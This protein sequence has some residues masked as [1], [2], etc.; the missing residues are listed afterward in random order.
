MERIEHFDEY[1]KIRSI[2]KMTAGR[3]GAEVHLLSG[4]QVAKYVK[5][6]LLSDQSAWEAYKRESLFYSEFS[7]SDHPYIPRVLYNE[8]RED[9]FLLIMRVYHPI[10]QSDMAKPE[11]L[12]KVL[13]TLRLIH[14]LP[15]PKFVPQTNAVPLTFD[16]E[17]LARCHNGWLSVLSGY[18]G[19][20]SV[21]ELNE[22]ASSIN[23]INRRLYQPKQCFV[24]GDFHCENILMDDQ[25]NIIVCDWQ[26]CG[27]GDA[28][29]DISFLLSRLS[30]DMQHVDAEMALALYCDSDSETK[31][32]LNQMRLSNLNTSFLYWHEYLH[33]APVERVANVFTNMTHDLRRLREEI[34]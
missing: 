4:R 14:G 15:I 6:E 25:R 16:E 8:L 26:N 7:S 9:E 31:K 22:V 33:G 5:R 24:H 30:A 17:N 28:S 10:S 21:H 34:A 1:L 27:V 13:S 11:I 19:R 2:K 18:D 12:G 23:E 20:F 29:G 3:S 32:I